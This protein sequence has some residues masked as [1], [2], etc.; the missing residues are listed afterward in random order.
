[1][2]NDLPLDGARVD[3]VCRG[4]HV[5][6]PLRE[7]CLAWRDG[8]RGAPRAHRRGRAHFAPLCG[9]P[10]CSHGVTAWDA[11]TN[12]IGGP[13]D[14]ISWVMRNRQAFL[15][16]CP[17]ATN[18]TCSCVFLNHDGMTPPAAWWGAGGEKRL[19]VWTPRG[20]TRVARQG[21]V[22]WCREES[23]SERAGDFPQSVPCSALMKEQRRAPGPV[24]SLK[25]AA[26]GGRNGFDA[27]CSLIISAAGANL[28]HSTLVI[29]PRAE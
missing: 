23:V 26:G 7:V 5:L 28:R 6:V 8:R 17:V 24:A 10:H 11:H 2:S 16:A 22:A 15:T 1:M 14:F 25:L 9:D 12:Q 13:G 20:N 27:Q 4:N 21:Q 19:N 29:M 18:Q 3:E